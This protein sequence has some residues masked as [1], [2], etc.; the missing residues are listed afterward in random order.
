MNAAPVALT[1]LLIS[2]E[3]LGSMVDI[4]MQVFPAPS[5]GRIVLY[6]LMECSDFG[7]IEMMTSDFSASSTESLQGT[8]PLEASSSTFAGMKSKQ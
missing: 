5:T 4:S 6:T 1:I 3:T 7:T 8:A 2:T